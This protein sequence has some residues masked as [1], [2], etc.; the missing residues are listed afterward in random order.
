MK[1]GVVD[2]ASTRQL[3]RAVLRPH[4]GPD[5][6]LPGDE[7]PNAT[8][9]AAVDDDARVIATCFGYREPCPWRPGERAWRLRQMATDPQHR[10][11]G[12]GA[13]ITTELA[14]LAT[15]D[16]AT[17]L[18]CHARR[19]AVPFYEH[20]GFRPHGPDFIENDIP[21]VAMWRPLG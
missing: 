17:V 18:W 4:L 16:E 11:E 2:G 3:R 21:H 20:C 10:G 1:V 5:D 6:P 7:L 13:A 8:H 14:R 15:A 12:W 19:Y 9:V